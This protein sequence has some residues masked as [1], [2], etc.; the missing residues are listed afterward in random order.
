MDLPESAR[1]RYH[2]GA[3]WRQRWTG[4]GFARGLAQ[5]RAQTRSHAQ[6]RAAW[7]PP[8]SICINQPP[9]SSVGRL[10]GGLVRGCLVR[11]RVG[12][13]AMQEIVRRLERLVVLGI[14]R[15]IGLRPG[16]LVT[17]GFQMTAQGG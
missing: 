14:R 12:L 9:R 7:R 1:R 5:A 11:G 10:A 4:Y 17:F 8:F 15:H 3:S 6:K 16:L 13:D 2:G